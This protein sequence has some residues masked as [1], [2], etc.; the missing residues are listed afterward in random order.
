MT[1]QPTTFPTVVHVH[2]TNYATAAA[3]A[4]AQA[5]AVPPAR[6]SMIGGPGQPITIHYERAE[7]TTPLEP[8]PLSWWDHPRARLRI[9]PPG[10]HQAALSYLHDLAGAHLAGVPNRP[11]AQDLALIFRSADPSPTDRDVLRQLLAA[12]PAPRFKS[13]RTLGGVS[14]Y[15]MARAV[16][17]TGSRRNAFIRWL[18]RFAVPPRPG[19][20]PRLTPPLVPQPARLLNCYHARYRVDLAEGRV[21]QDDLGHGFGRRPPTG[22]RAGGHCRPGPARLFRRL[23]SLPGG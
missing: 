20:P 11:T 15:E 2:N 8:L 21:R 5:A 6:K 18:H 4:T 16:H 10:G 9:L 3:A 13:L 23:A 14:L 19:R 17:V 7:R 12:L 1:E 22:R